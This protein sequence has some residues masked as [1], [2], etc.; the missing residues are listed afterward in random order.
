MRAMASRW[1]PGKGP[2]RRERPAPRPPGWAAACEAMGAE[3][4]IVRECCGP[5]MSV[6]PEQVS[7]ALA[8]AIECAEASHWSTCFDAK[9]AA[10][11][12]RGPPYL[13]HLNDFG[14]LDRAKALYGDAS[15]AHDIMQRLRDITNSVPHDAAAV[16][17]LNAARWIVRQYEIGRKVHQD[18]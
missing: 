16:A 14:W 7:A 1:T 2:G 17:S 6:S 8:L 9:P 10:G 15:P 12:G 13:L 18:L 11:E 4:A 3:D 5:G